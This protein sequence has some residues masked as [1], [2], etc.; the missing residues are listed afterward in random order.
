MERSIIDGSE[1]E[2]FEFTSMVQT[3]EPLARGYLGPWDLC[4]NK[5]NKGPSG[6]ATYQILSAWAKQFW[7]RRF[8]SIFHF[9]PK[10]PCCRA[11]SDS[12]IFI[13]INLVEIHYAM[14]HTKYQGPR[15]SGFRGDVVWSN[16]SS[17]VPTA[18]WNWGYIWSYSLFLYPQCI[19]AHKGPRH[20]WGY[21]PNFGGKKP[22]AEGKWECCV[23][24]TWWMTHNGHRVLA[25]AHL[26]SMAQVD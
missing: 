16:C 22:S 6:N 9:E 12:G 4:L 20:F 13:W 23:D 11:I 14:L 2:D 10:T 8:L 7:R 17:R 1:E 21:K 18:F 24:D 15:P 26:Q 25:I 5:V 3:E 19:A